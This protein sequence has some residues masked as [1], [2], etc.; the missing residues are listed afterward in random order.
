LSGT[1]DVLTFA[2]PSAVEGVVAAIEPVTLADLR[3]TTA[4]A[5]IGPTTLEAVR[6]AGTDADIVPPEATVPAMLDAIEHY[7]ERRTHE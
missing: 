5:V 3:K 1:I 2:S 4:I 6:G 7:L